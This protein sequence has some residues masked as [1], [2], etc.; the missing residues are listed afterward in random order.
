M[1]APASNSFGFEDQRR[2]LIDDFHPSKWCHSPGKRAFDVSVSLFLLLCAAAAAPGDR[3][4]DQNQLIG[5]GAFRARTRGP[6]WQDV[7]NA[8]ISDH[9]PCQARKLHGSHAHRRSAGHGAGMASPAV[10]TGRTAAAIQRDS[11]GHD[12]SSGRGHISRACWGIVP[13][14]AASW[15]FVRAS[16][17]WPPC[18][19]VTR[20]IP[21][22]G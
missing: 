8:E 16:P 12:A 2:P 9:D 20:K 22:P 14:Y 1:A 4:V 15:R 5:P 6:R 11:W 3:L 18:Y 17:A 7:P 10:E 19:S 21:C 13:I